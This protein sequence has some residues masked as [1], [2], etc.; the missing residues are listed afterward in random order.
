MRRA[1]EYHFELDTKPK[2]I[3]LHFVRV[4]ITAASH[5]QTRAEKN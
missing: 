1:V 3:Q 5:C 2:I 4:G